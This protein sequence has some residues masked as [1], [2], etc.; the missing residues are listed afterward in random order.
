MIQFT[1]LPGNKTVLL[2]IDVQ[3]ALFTRPTPVYEDSR[4]IEII[5]GL[6]DLAHLYHIQVIYIQHSNQSILREGTDG[7]KLHPGLKPG[8]EDLNIIKTQ[9]NAFKGTT[10]RSILESRGLEN[11]IVTG[12]VTQG[13][14]RA[15]SLGGIELGY[16]M[17]LVKGGH[18]NY[19]EDAPAII[20]AHEE[21]LEKAGVNLVS[22]DELA[23]S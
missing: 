20:Q 23:F 16:N 14:I 11:L 5:N 19:N 21:D 12:L 1:T 22:M 15:T 9:G 7:F 13:C 2:I 17:Y 10:L 8:P 6:V 18:T 4:M 3:R